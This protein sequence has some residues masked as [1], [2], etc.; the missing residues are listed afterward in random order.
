MVGLLATLAV[1]ST[2]D[3]KPHAPGI[4]C[5]TYPAAPACLGQKPACNTCH[6]KTTTPVVLNGY[7]K[8]VA[9]A[10]EAYIDNPFDNAQFGDYLAFALVDVEALD[11]DA[12]GFENGDE[13]L[14]GTFPGDATSIPGQA[15]CPEDTSGLAYPI[16]EY[17]YSFAYRK[18]GIDFC[19]MPPTF[20]EMEAFR[21]L[22]ADAQ[23]AE[24]HDKLDACLDTQFWLGFDG[25][26]W[27]LAHEKIRPLMAFF[28]SRQNFFADYG[29]FVWSQID[30]HDV[31][32][33]LTADYHVGITTPLGEDDLSYLEY[34]MEPSIPDQ[35]LEQDR[36]AGMLTLAWPLFYN[37]MFTALPRTTAAQAYRAFLGLDIAKSEG[38]DWPID[39]EPVDYDSSGV[40]Q[41]EC[42]QCH[43]TLDPLAYPFATYNGLQADTEIGL[44]E[45]DPNRIEKYFGQQFPEMLNMPEA[46][47]IFGEPVAD[48]IEWAEVAANSDAFYSARAKDYWTLLMG[49]APRPDQA[50]SYAE[51]TALWEGLRET[52]SIEDMLHQLIETEAYGAP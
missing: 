30:G 17:D 34:S 47:Y 15:E 52:N 37:T 51:F 13:L 8:D 28:D 1:A 33:M 24:L 9:V 31:R 7:G 41:A 4:I 19:G 42:A 25:V 12:D 39:G 23:N 29:I 50:E 36:R 43:S 27:S 46:G 16:C 22:G 35:P 38:L 10:L 18:V 32:E 45:Y 20:E 11:S 6:E 40:T 49:Q 3:A 2:A 26:L 5:D 14:E 21:A 44:F 48:L